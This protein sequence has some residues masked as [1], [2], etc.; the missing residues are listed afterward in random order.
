MTQVSVVTV[1][2][3]ADCGKE[4]DFLSQAQSQHP[5]RRLAPRPVGQAT[6]SMAAGIDPDAI[7]PRSRTPRA[8][9]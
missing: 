5:P 6:A 4:T 9:A 7:E 8:E 2:S 1:Y 3:D